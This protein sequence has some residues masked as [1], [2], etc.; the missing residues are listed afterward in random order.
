MKSHNKVALILCGG[1]INFSDLPIVTNRSNAMIPVNSRPVIGWILEDLLKKGFVEVVLVLRF[2]NTRLFNYV[3]WAF[4]QRIQVHCAFVQPGGTILHSL[5]SG[6]EVVKPEYGVHIVLG[7]TLI[8]DSLPD[9]KDFVFSGPFKSPEDWC[10]VE[11]DKQGR[12]VGYY[13][14]QG[15]AEPD[16]QALAGVYSLSDVG[17]LKRV[18]MEKIQSGLKEI[19][20]VLTGY[21]KQN[22]IYVEPAKQWYDFGHIDYFNLAKQKLLQSRYFNSLN[23]DPLRGTITKTSE[24]SE[25]L[26]DELN[27]YRALPQNLRIFSPRLEEVETGDKVTITQEYYGYPNLA[28]LYVF[29]DLAL[30]VWKN[31]LQRLM[32]IQKLFK[33]ETGNVQAEDVWDMY[34]VKTNQRLD[35]LSKQPGWKERLSHET[36]VINGM[37]YKNFGQLSKSI[38][39]LLIKLREL[40]SGSIIHGDYCFSNILYDLNTQVVRLID[41]RGS[42]GKQ[43]LYGDPRYDIAKLRHS[44]AGRYDFIIADL[45]KVEEENAEYTF[46]V[47]EPEV[48]SPLVKHFDTLIQVYGYAPEEIRL[49]EGLLFISMVPLHRDSPNRQLAM[50]LTGIQILNNVINADRN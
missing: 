11:T 36:L 7:D 44:I 1:D 4:G 14:K 16:W 17:L 25:K 5:L 49:I 43:K 35:E 50:Y 33:Q 38:E 45:F 8:Q 41:P 6:L 34:H 23:I 29:G 46:E 28:E 15:K 12:A 2:D 21:G 9:H 13:D 3:T 47:V 37:S 39:S 27:W 30:T 48:Y 24:K 18:V 22:P 19:S 40:C 31:A 42:F 10:L 26:A 32:E 20:S